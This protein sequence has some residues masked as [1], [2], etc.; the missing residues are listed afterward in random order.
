M[1]LLNNKVLVLPSRH[2]A[3]RFKIEVASELCIYNYDARSKSNLT[4]KKNRSFEGF[5][6][7]H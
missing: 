1:A 5:I 2:K 6:I 4:S 3:D 7:K